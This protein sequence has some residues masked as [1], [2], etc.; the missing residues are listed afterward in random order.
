MADTETI[1]SEGDG[2]GV[3]PALP[4]VSW[5]AIFGGVVS[6]MGIWILLYAFGVAIGLSVVDPNDTGS[7]KG[8]GIFT[9]IWGVFA[10]LVALFIGGAVAG[11]LAGVFVRSQGA[12][13]GLIMW[14]LA[15]VAGTYMVLA[16]VGS[17]LSGAGR[18][19]TVAGEGV[20]S[21][22]GA[23][24]SG[25]SGLLDQV[26]WNDVL[27]P[28]NQ[29][30][31]AEGKPPLTASQLQAAGK[32]AMRS[33]LTNGRI[34]RGAIEQSLAQNTDLSRADVQDI[35]GRLQTKL[36]STTQ[37]AKSSLQGAAQQATRGALRAADATGKALWGVFG[38]L[39][40]GLIAAVAGGSM[41]VFPPHLRRRPR[42]PS[43]TLEP[44]ATRPTT[45]RR[46]SFPRH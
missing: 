40:L 11:R 25:A 41:G 26:S 33:A 9:G 18:V 13:H 45:P 29:R 37:Q 2:K 24:V 46:E 28:V 21:A 7:L 6:A 22:A 20:A 16:T 43:A 1:E 34:D 44:P 35:A 15:T 32:D 12:M 31:R 10:P 27:T 14:G 8:S 19:A 17:I 36:D 39:A 3:L 5:G 30:L 4:R 42:G 23:G 38:A